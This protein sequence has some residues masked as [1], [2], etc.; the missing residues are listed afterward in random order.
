[1][2]ENEV[3]TVAA[4]HPVELAN[5][6]MSPMSALS[7]NALFHRAERLCTLAAPIAALLFFYV[8]GLG[9]LLGAE[10]NAAIE[11]MWPT[12]ARAP[13]AFDRRGWQRLDDVDG[14][15]DESPPPP[16]GMDS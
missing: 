1:L 12:P 2:V 13:R 16:G 7:S 14:Q 8:L 5:T 11:Q 15:P 10:F 3:A 4:V 6:V 9:V